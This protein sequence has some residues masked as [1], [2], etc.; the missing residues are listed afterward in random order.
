M[1]RPGF[2]ARINSPVFPPNLDAGPRLALIAST[3][4]VDRGTII[5]RL[6]FIDG[7]DVARVIDMKDAKRFPRQFC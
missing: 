2:E 4:V 3:R 1:R 6:E 7:Q 5:D